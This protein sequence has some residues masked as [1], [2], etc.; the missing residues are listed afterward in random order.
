MGWDE[1]NHDQRL[2]DFGDIILNKHNTQIF[3]HIP[4]RTDFENMIEDAGMKI[5]E[6]FSWTEL[7]IEEQKNAVPNSQKCTY[8][9]ARK[10]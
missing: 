5:T 10:Y 3:I 1:M 9:I 4:K 2:I 8:W 6:R 7:V